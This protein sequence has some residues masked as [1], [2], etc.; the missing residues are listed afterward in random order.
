[1]HDLLAFTIVGIVTGAIYAV[2][3][4]GLVVTYTTSGVFN[5]AH[6]AIGMVGAF[7]YWELRVNRHMPAPIALVVGAPLLGALIERLFMRRLYG[8]PTG[9]AI[10]VTVALMV[11]LLYGSQSVWKQS[12]N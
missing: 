1:M 7:S 11:F 4:S 3:A 2:A 6:G 10:V 5:F 8:K 9:V 12:G